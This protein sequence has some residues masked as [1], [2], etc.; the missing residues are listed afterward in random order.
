MVH[1]IGVFFRGSLNTGGRGG[2]EDV[3]EISLSVLH[4]DLCT[5][6]CLHPIIGEQH[7]RGNQ[8]HAPLQTATRNRTIDGR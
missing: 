5:P 1:T 4:L 3:A 8:E 2:E 7:Q 6:V